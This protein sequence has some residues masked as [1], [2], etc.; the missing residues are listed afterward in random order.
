MTG[1]TLVW[2]SSGDGFRRDTRR[3]PCP[4]LAAADWNAGLGRAADRFVDLVTSDEEAKQAL[5]RPAAL[6][7]SLWRIFG[8]VFLHAV[9]FYFIYA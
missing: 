3:A 2:G 8:A 6:Q 1:P 7:M 9:L 5:S 4:R